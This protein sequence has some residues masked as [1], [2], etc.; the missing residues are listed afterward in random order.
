[1]ENLYTYIP[2]IK[3]RYVIV[4][5]DDDREEAIDKINRPQFRDIEARYFP[6]SA[7]EEL[8]YIC[9]HRNSRGITDAFLD[10]YMEKV[11]V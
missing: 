7:V 2:S 5:P 11:V 4:A 6:Y 9:S 8:F 3:T 1:M 10:S